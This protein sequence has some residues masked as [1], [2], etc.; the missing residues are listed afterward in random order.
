[1]ER[2]EVKAA[3]IVISESTVLNIQHVFMIAMATV[4]PS[5]FYQLPMDSNPENV[6]RNGGAESQE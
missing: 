2:L 4:H 1:M 6:R 3:C 5:C